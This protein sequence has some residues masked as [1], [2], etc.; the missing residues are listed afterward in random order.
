MQCTKLD[1]TVVRIDIKHVALLDLTTQKFQFTGP[2][3]VGLHYLFVRDLRSASANHSCL[4]SH[5][6]VQV[7]YGKVWQISMSQPIGNRS[8][9]ECSTRITS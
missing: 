8:T 9:I 5:V 1:A 4:G 7:R 3:A 6:A 2:L